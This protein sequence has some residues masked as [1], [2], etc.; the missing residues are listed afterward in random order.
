MRV[1]PGFAILPAILLLGCAPRSTPQDLA[2][3]FVYVSGEPVASPSDLRLTL[4]D[5][6]GAVQRSVLIGQGERVIALVDTLPGQH[7]LEASLGCDIG[8]SLQSGKET[9]VVLEQFAGGCQIRLDRNHDP[10]ELGHA[11]AT[12]SVQVTDASKL[13][14]APVSVMSVDSPPNP[15]PSPQSADEGGR[16]YFYDLVPGKYRFFVTLGDMIFADDNVAIKAEPATN[17]VVIDLTP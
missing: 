10:G 17:E 9:D 7:V 8:L 1:R 11:L 4:R 14:D 5:Q 2:A 16:I 15:V 13:G 12:A 6:D 3:A